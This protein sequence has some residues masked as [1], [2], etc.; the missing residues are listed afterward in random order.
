MPKGK[1]NAQ[2]IASAKY[3]QK[4]GYKTKGFYLKGDVADRF[5]EACNKIGISQAS[6]ISELMEQFITEVE[7]QG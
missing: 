3:H 6:K 1:P 7:H 2:T 4:S 5:A